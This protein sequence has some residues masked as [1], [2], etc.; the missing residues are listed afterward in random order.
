M[1]SKEKWLGVILI[2]VVN[3]INYYLT[4]PSIGW[5]SYTLATLSIDTGI[6]LV[7]WYAGRGIVLYLDH[8]V[9]Y[10]DGVSRR[11]L[12][13]LALTLLT[14]IAVIVALTWLTNVLWSDSAI[15][16]NFFAFDLII[17]AIWIL[18]FNGIYINLYF[19]QARKPHQKIEL[20]EGKKR[21]LVTYDQLRFFEYRN[22]LVYAVTSSNQKLHSNQNLSDLEK[23]VGMDFF[24]ANRQ[25]LISRASVKSYMP[26][27]NGKLICTLHD[28]GEDR[29]ISVSREKAKAFKNWIREATVHH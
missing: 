29:A 24:K 25:F 15:P 22:Q 2:P 3:L 27:Q 9:P 10:A 4:Y 17:F 13:Q 14:M 6:G 16:S 1:D 5:D 23:T 11:I 7:A 12:L 21:V 19:Y 28:H 26:D 8:K 20:F 18:V